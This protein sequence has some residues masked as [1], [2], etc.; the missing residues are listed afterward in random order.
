MELYLW[1]SVYSSLKWACWNATQDFNSRNSLFTHLPPAHKEPCTDHRL[2]EAKAMSIL[3]ITMSPQ[4]E[5]GP[6]HRSRCSMM[7]AKWMKA[8]NH[9][10]GRSER[11]WLK[12]CGTLRPHLPS[13]TPGPPW[14][15]QDCGTPSLN[16]IGFSSTN[17]NSLVSVWH[18]ISWSVEIH[19]VWPKFT[20]LKD[21]FSHFT[22]YFKVL[23]FKPSYYTF[24][25]SPCRRWKHFSRQ[26]C[27]EWLHGNEYLASLM[28][29]SHGELLVFIYF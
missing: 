23:V 29:L 16:T 4:L 19:L 1:V 18:T 28:C 5:Q 12:Q 6:A 2:H 21:S 14:E 20:W 15:H 26:A 25:P 22:L 3:I 17:H 9:P 11:S 13:F 27:C 8:D 24:P 7:C 10:W